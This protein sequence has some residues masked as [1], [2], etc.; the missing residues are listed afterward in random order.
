MLFGFIMGKELYSCV[1]Q[2]Q[3]PELEGRGHGGMAEK[4]ALWLG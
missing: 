2:P 4:G 1:K 3:D